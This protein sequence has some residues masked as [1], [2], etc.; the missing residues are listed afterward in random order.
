MVK[1]RDILVNP[2][3]TLTNSAHLK[4]DNLKLSFKILKTKFRARISQLFLEEININ[5]CIKYHYGSLLE[6]FKKKIIASYMTTALREKIPNG[7]SCGDISCLCTWHL[8]PGLSE[9]SFQRS[10]M[11]PFSTIL[12]PKSNCFSAT[13]AEPA[14]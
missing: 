6:H 10:L 2:Q 1:D 12:M 11:G 7:K 8:P 3:K 14:Q 13:R 4:R 5:L 9:K